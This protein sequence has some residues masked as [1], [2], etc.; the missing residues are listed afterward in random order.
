MIKSFDIKGSNKWPD[1]SSLKELDVKLLGKIESEKILFCYDG[2]PILFTTSTNPKYLMY[3]V[4]DI[5]NKTLIRYLFSI[6]TDKILDDIEKNRI[7][8]RNAILQGLVG[9]VDINDLNKFVRAYNISKDDVPSNVLP[10]T[11]TMLNI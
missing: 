7:T 11:G 5:D 3:C 6:I 10:I 2:T 9:F 4:G 8:V 1:L